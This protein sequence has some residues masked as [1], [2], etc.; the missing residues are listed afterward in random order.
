MWLP[1]YYYRYRRTDSIPRGPATRHGAGSPTA[2]CGYASKGGGGTTWHHSEGAGQLPSSG[3]GTIWVGERQTRPWYRRATCKLQCQHRTTLRP[4]WRCR[5]HCAL[6]HR[7]LHWSNIASSSPPS[8]Q[9]PPDGSR[10][11][12]TVRRSNTVQHRN[13]N[14]C[15]PATVSALVAFH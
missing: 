7:R 1:F 12:C 9:S 15:H 8:T 10:G 4:Q 3:R 13:H 2:C 14:A 11:D 6:T 5:S